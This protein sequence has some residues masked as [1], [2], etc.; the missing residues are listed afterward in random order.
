MIQSDIFDSFNMDIKKITSNA[1]LFVTKRLIEFSGFLISLFGFVILLAL[2][3]YSPEDPN[4]IFSEG[5]E[6]KNLLGFQGSFLSDIFFQSIG[7]MSYLV[8]ITLIFS[9]INIFIKKECR[10]GFS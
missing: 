6:I 1:M 9:G 8:A 7:L 3:T 4:F 5:T 2:I 10:V